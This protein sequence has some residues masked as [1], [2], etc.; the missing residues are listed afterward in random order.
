MHDD[1]ILCT[2]KTLPYLDKFILVKLVQN[3]KCHIRSQTQESNPHPVVAAIGSHYV[4]EGLSGLI[5]PPCFIFETCACDFVDVNYSF[6]D[7]IAKIRKFD[8]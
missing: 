5:P 1:N 4:L 3:L 2:L 8:F 7:S 6:E